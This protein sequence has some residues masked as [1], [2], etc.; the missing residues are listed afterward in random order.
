[1]GN[2]SDSSGMVDVASVRV[3]VFWKALPFNTM[4]LQSFYAHSKTRVKAIDKQRDKYCDLQ[5]HQPLMLNSGE[6]KGYQYITFS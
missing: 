1:M 4:I 3:N 5:S 6:F 2:A